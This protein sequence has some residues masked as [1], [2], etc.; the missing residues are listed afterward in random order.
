MIRAMRQVQVTEKM[1][2]R[3]APAR[4]RSKWKMEAKTACRAL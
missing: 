4:M 3:A 1:M 2:G